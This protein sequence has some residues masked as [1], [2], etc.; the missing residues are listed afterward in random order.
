MCNIAFA[1]DNLDLDVE[2]RIRNN[3]QPQNEYGHTYKSPDMKHIPVVNSFRIK[4]EDSTNTITV[5]CP[6]V[7]QAINL[8][9]AISENIIM[10]SFENCSSDDVQR[11]FRN[12]ADS[13]MEYVFAPGY[14]HYST[15]HVLTK[16]NQ[17]NMT[18][19]EITI[20]VNPLAENAHLK[21]FT[22]ST[23]YVE[24]TQ[25]S[26]PKKIRRDEYEDT[27]FLQACEKVWLNKILVDRI[28]ILPLDV[29]IYAAVDA[30]P[31]HTSPEELSYD[32]SYKIVHEAVE[33]L[34]L[35]DLI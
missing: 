22:L 28:D 14:R 24:T 17:D 16:D 3:L 20:E 25:W 13:G 1:T 30:I 33:D 6:T 35:D 8:L 34:S 10:V 2:K 29:V 26:T 12:K 11:T 21:D 27:P 4:E 23:C 15:V 18:V 19:Y 7:T 31:P 32:A 5:N 9:E